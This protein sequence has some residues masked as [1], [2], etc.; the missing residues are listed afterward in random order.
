M[1][2]RL[3][4]VQPILDEMKNLNNDEIFWLIRNISY[5]LVSYYDEEHKGQIYNGSYDQ[6]QIEQ[7]T[8]LQ[9]RLR[10]IADV[11]NQVFNHRN[12]DNDYF[13]DLLTDGYDSKLKEQTKIAN[14]YKE[15]AWKYD[16]LCD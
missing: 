15:K 8:R 2:I 6:L 1:E 16:Q 12:F 3:E 7:A 11:M 9:Q 5:D 14:E 13:E 4:K 10:T